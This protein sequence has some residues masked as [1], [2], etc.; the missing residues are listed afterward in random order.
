[1]RVGGWV[2][3]LA[4]GRRR[5][6]GRVGERADRQADRRRRDGRGFA[7][8]LQRQPLDDLDSQRIET[9]GWRLIVIRLSSSLLVAA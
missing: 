1:M 5:A 3:E 8:K 2:D 4:G 6:G 9:R 7:K